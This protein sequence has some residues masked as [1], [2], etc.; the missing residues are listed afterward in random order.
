MSHI[1]I[2]LIIRVYY[3]KLQIVYKNNMEVLMMTRVAIPND[4][5]GTK[6][7]RAQDLG[8]PSILQFRGPPPLL[9]KKKACLNFFIILLEYKYN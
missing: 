8:A 3:F 2:S 5:I 7:G 1:Y 4:T 6:Q 9:Q